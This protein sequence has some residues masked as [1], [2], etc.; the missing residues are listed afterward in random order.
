MQALIYITVAEE[1]LFSYQLPL[2]VW[3]KQQPYKIVCYDFD[4]H[5]EALVANYAIQLLEQADK[6]LIVIDC[7]EATISQ[8]R[9]NIIKLLNKAVRQKDKGVKLVLNGNDPI[10]EKMGKA[11]GKNF[12]PHQ[13]LEAQKT[14]CQEFFMKAL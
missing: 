14:L 11:L 5:S 2:L 8:Q 1:A 7:K 3:V 4:N 6:I 13:T 10:F 9:G 12:Y